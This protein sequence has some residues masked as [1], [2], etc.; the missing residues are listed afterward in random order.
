MRYE[1]DDGYPF[2]TDEV[3]TPYLPD[4]LAEDGNLYVLP[5]GKYLPSGC[6]RTR[7][8]GHLI[9]D[10]EQLSPYAG[11]LAQLATGRSH[12]GGR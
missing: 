11:M 5:N 8:G 3:G 1:V 2:E 12:R 9:Y 4:G 7:D 10:P 6:Y